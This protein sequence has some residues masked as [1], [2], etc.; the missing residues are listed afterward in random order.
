MKKPLPRGPVSQ[1]LANFI[2]LRDGGICIYCVDAVGQQIDHVIP[3]SVGGPT[4]KSNLVLSCQACNMEKH[5]RL[6]EVMLARAFKHLM[7]VGENID[8]VDAF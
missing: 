8:W 5:G 1:A 4:I 6:H 2:R 3:L 7:K